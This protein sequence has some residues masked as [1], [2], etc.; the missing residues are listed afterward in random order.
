MARD[1][2]VV[3]TRSAEETRS[4]GERIGELLS[5]GAVLALHG[6]LGAGKTCLVK[7]LARGLGIDGAVNVSSPSFVI[8]NEYPGRVPLFHFDLYRIHDAREMIDLDWEDYL[9]RGGVIAIEWAERMQELLPDDHL[10]V[11]L[12]I[13][14][15]RSRKI[16]F[17][18]VGVAGIADVLRR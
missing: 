3:I 14:G 4:L 15:E 8:I 1:E 11:R 2:Y 9:D 13:T 10:G 17:S 6:E 18:G 16:V 12:E 7:G 5:P